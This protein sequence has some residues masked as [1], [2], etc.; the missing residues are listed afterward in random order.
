MAWEREALPTFI[1]PMLAKPGPVPETGTHAHEPKLDGCRG[2]VSIDHGVLRIRS[3]KRTDFT[4]RFPELQALADEL[5]ARQVLLD[6]EIVCLGDTGKP[7]FARLRRRL[8]TGSRRAAS[9]QRTCPA[10]FFAF[11]LL[12]LGGE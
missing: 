3:R 2:L 8:V 11:D 7:D 12:H 10:T 6:G 5:A 4:D 9:L 1:A